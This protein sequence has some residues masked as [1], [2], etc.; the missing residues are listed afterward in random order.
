M[1]FLKSSSLVSIM[2]R[3]M[4]PR[5]S[6]SNPFIMNALGAWSQLYADLYM[7]PKDRFHSKAKNLI[8]SIMENSDNVLHERS[9]NLHHIIGGRVSV[10]P[11]DTRHV[12]YEIIP[13]NIADGC[14]YHCKFCCVKSSRPFLARTENDIIQQIQRLKQ[15]YGRNLY[16]YQSLFLG[17]HDAL[18]ACR[19]TTLEE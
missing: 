2:P 12:D 6:L 9:E 19:S 8:S 7:A 15:L 3:L 4:F 16:N 10:L 13:L 14:L 1:P 11:P 5:R 17:N 18:A